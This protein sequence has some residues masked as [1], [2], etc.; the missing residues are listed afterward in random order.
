MRTIQQI[1]QKDEKLSI[2]LISG[3]SL[4]GVDT[5]LVRIKKSGLETKVKLIHFIT[6]PYP[7]GLKA[8]L[9]EIS[10][11]SNGSVDEI[12]R[13]NVVLGEIFA[14]AIKALLNKA[15]VNADEVDFIG[16][17][18]QTVHHL[19]KPEKVFDYT[20]TSTL[21]L[22]EPSVIAKRAGILTVADFRPADMALGGQGA[23]LVPYLDFTLFRSLEKSR[24]L[25]NIGGIANFTILKNGCSLS[26]VI[27]FDTGPG[28]M[29]IDFLMNELFLSPFDE[30]GEIASSGRIS[31]QL[32]DLTLKHP[33]FK[34]QPPKSTG[35]E[36]FGSEFCEFFLAESERLNLTKEDCITTASELTVRSIL[37]ALKNFGSSSEIVL[38][39][40][41]VSGGGT[42]NLY[43][44]EGLAAA[45]GGVPVKPTDKYGIPSAAK[46]AIL[47]AL[48][49]NETICGNPGNVP[50]V[51]GANA[52]TILG[53]ICL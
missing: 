38:D 37:A 36:E 6:F 30:N 13:Y 41:I 33:Y 22:G 16:S 14:D 24:A 46:E 9:L 50:S 3:T 51:T 40:I 25:L 39:E 47:F 7:E 12:C 31:A 44:M 1:Q 2:G 21:Q 26:D 15:G 29:L 23:P 20:I 49:A 11:P 48:L 19:P 53:K 8:K 10:N 52:P 35:R 45:S 27:A 43:I 17:H 32:L 42:E 5:A 4:D 34:K 18:G 28:N